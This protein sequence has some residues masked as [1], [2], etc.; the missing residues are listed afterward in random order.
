MFSSQH[1][2]ARLLFELS[3]LLLTIAAFYAAYEVRSQI[4]F[5]ERDFFIL[6]SN[7][8]SSLSLR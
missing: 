1:R 2:K 6:P 3:D 7:R 8:F 4:T 5:L